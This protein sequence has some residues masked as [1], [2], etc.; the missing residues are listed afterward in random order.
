MKKTAKY[1]ENQVKEAFDELV[2]IAKC[3][4]LLGE[5]AKH[6]KSRH[7][8]TVEGF[9]RTILRAK[10]KGKV[11]ILLSQRTESYGPM[12]DI[13]G[14]DQ[15][16]NLRNVVVVEIK[17][18]FTN[19]NGIPHKTEEAHGLPKDLEAL[20]TARNNGV[21]LTYELVV[22]FECYAVNKKG[23]YI[24]TSKRD[25]WEKYGIKYPTELGYVHCEGEEKVHDAM[26]RLSKDNGLKGKRIK[27]WKRVQLPSPHSNI[28]AFLDC[29]LYKVLLK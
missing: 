22:M 4:R 3:S 9:F 19:R 23:K 1:I 13:V 16:H 28:H 26:K 5:I 24:R 10:L 18:P 8:E 29:A 21:R 14:L 2:S 15:K 6:P 20:A 27:G 7:E 11:K 17:T 25:L 12:H